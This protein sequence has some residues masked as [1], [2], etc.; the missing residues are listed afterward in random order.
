MRAGKW[1]EA[2]ALV[3]GIGGILAAA[4]LMPLS[5]TVEHAE[6]AAM[7]PIAH[8]DPFDRLLAA[9]ALEENLVLVSVDGAFLTVS[10]LSIA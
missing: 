1:P 2:A 9:Q 7:L 6:R 8:K 4:K 3:P 10:G 5:V